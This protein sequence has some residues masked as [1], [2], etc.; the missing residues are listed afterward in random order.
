MLNSSAK[1]NHFTNISKEELFSLITFSQ[2][3]IIIIKNADKYST[4]V[5]TNKEVYF[6]EV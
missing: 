6:K 3:K 2:D 1:R 5:I 4:I